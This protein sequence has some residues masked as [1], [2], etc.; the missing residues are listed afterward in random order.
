[1]DRRQ[2]L[3]LSAA[4]SLIAPARTQGLQRERKVK[5]A[6]LST[7]RSDEDDNLGTRFYSALRAHGWIEGKNVTYER[8]FTEGSRDRLDQMAKAAVASKPDLIFTPTAGA[9]RAARRATPTIPIVFI[10]ASD[11]IAAGLVS[12]LARPGGNATGVF[13]MS[14]ASTP[15]RMELAQELLPG[16]TRIGIVIDRVAPDHGNQ[17]REYETAARLLGLPI[18][19]AEF[20][21]FDEVPAAVAK[22]KAAGASVLMMNASFT[23]AARRREFAD[24]ALR[25]GLALFAY[26]GEWADSGALLS[27]GAHLV[28]G[29]ERSAGMAHRILMGTKPEDMP[30]EQASRFELVLNLRTAKTLGIKPTP[31]FLTRA[32]RV[33]E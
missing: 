14:A 11:P 5:V 9:G 24:S 21:S 2:F 15:K 13:H 6:V 25:N 3:V 4:L 12:S 1:L 10:A 26:R 29:H 7:G 18:T 23:L 32:D 30:V 22:V 8:F 27:Y 33:I 20:A 28:E 16:T 31:A 17:R 19:F